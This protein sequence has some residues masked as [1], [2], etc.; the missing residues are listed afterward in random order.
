MQDL[1]IN[2]LRQAWPPFAVGAVIG[3]IVG[4]LL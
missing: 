2:Y 3:F 1:I 4:V